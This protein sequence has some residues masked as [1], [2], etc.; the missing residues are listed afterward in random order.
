MQKVLYALLEQELALL[1]VFQI[2]EALK[3]LFSKQEQGSGSLLRKK[4]LVGV[5]ELESMFNKYELVC[6]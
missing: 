5:K 2:T 6:Y 4:D 3:I 1:Q